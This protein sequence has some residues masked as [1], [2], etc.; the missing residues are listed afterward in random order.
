VSRSA[1]SL[2]AAVLIGLATAI[3][4]VTVAIV[5]FLSPQWV[6]FEQDR[7][8]AAA[9]TGFTT[10][11]LRT[12]TD[13]I[14]SDLVLGGD[15]DFAVDGKPVLEERE[16]AHMADVRT[17]FRG[18]WIL[19]AVSIVVLVL[20]SRRRDRAGVWQA[21][22]GGAIGLTIGVVIA[23]VVGLVAFDQ[24]FETFHRIFFPP[25]SYLFDPL[26]DRLVQLFPFAFWQE[27]A[28]VVGVVIIGIALVVATVAGRRARR[29]A[30]MENST[31]GLEAAA[32]P[33]T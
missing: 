22:R 8:Q 17:V 15:F 12:A 7:A 6:A 5:P 25:G 33:G 3:V 4:I 18:L 27:T 26:T 20:A 23:G 9:W 24:L 19:A 11:D 32:E 1:T 2:L 10:E 16:Q 21:V 30:V 14:L 31:V 13:A 29:S 28:I